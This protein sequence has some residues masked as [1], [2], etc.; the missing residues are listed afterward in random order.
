MQNT[1]STFPLLQVVI[2]IQ[3]RLI[4][5]TAAIDAWN[6]QWGEIFW[7][8]FSREDLSVPILH[9][10]CNIIHFRRHPTSNTRNSR[11]F[12]TSIKQIQKIF[13]VKFDLCITD[14]LSMPYSKS[15]AHKFSHKSALK[16]ES[17]ECGGKLENDFFL[18]SC[19]SYLVWQAGELLLYLQ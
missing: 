5:I 11:L 13:D 4:P 15:H 14:S 10:S 18:L 19:K 8:L 2:F 12:E 17:D 16:R 1:H 7:P 9:H 3:P 6:G